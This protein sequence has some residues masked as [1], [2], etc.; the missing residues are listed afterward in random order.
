[1][2]I[3]MEH[4]DWWKSSSLYMGYSPSV[5]SHWRD[6]GRVLFL[7]VYG[8]RR[9]LAAIFTE[10]AWSIKDLLYDFFRALKKSQLH[11]QSIGAL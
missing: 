6:I 10:Q 2:N 4:F 1:M 9:I 3:R 5:R 8:P 7:R 11:A